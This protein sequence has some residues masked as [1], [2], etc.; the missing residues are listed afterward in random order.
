MTMKRRGDDAEEQISIE[1]ILAREGISKEDVAR[2][3]NYAIF[4]RAL[5]AVMHHQKPA[6]ETII[7]FEALEQM[8]RGHVD[9]EMK[10]KDTVLDAIKELTR[11]VTE[12]KPTVKKV[13]DIDTFL[14]VGNKIGWIILLMVMAAIVGLYH[15]GQDLFRR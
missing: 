9:D 10:W 4:Y 2:Y 11:S 15:F 5:R 14:A 7:R 1:E 6:K 13:S 8:I 12:M 3:D